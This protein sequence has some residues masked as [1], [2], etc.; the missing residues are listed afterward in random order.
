MKDHLEVP[1]RDNAAEQKR[2]RAQMKG[3]GKLERM[4]GDNRRFSRNPVPLGETRVEVPLETT[5]A[6]FPTMVKEW[7]PEVGETILKDGVSNSKIG[8]KVLLGWL[9]GAR[10]F[11]LSLE[12]RATCPRSCGLWTRCYGNQ[13]PHARRWKHG[14]AFEAA[15][16]D[17][18]RDLCAQHGKVLI[19]LHVLGDFY[20]FDYLKMWVALLDQLPGLHIFGFTAHAPGSEIGAAIARVRQALGMRFAIRHSGFTGQWGTFTVP[21]NTGQKRYGD[22][23]VCPEQ[24][25]ASGDDRSDRHCGN[26]GFCWSNGGPLVFIEH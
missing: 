18:V 15:L 12:E 11:T 5:G 22:A 14:K 24:R 1:P 16:A 21:F 20:S 13:M 6:L 7:T 26:C 2:Y 4:R 8:G 19:R 10:I 17:E 23:V 9:K 25:G 3:R